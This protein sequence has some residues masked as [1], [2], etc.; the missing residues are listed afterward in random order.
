M[1]AAQA[2]EREAH[3][4]ANDRWAV[5]AALEDLDAERER[6]DMSA[7]EVEDAEDALLE[8]LIAM[9]GLAPPDGDGPA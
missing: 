6:G 5:Q 4:Q 2:I 7:A 3:R 1:L 8:R 9:R